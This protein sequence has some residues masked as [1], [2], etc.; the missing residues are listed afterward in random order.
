MIESNQNLHDIARNYINGNL[1]DSIKGIEGLSVPEV[2]ELLEIAQGQ[3]GIKRHQL[4]AFIRNRFE[5]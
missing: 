4:S 5:L 3:Y 2:L 1:K